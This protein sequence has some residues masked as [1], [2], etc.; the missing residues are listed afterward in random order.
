[1]VDELMPFQP[2]PRPRCRPC[3]WRGLQS[4]TALAVTWDYQFGF[5]CLYAGIKVPLEERPLNEDED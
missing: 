2:P 3:Y 1:V 5:H 4:R